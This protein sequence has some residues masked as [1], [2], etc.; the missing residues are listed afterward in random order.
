[1][2][3]KHW[4]TYTQCKRDV[5]HRDPWMDIKMNSGNFFFLLSTTLFEYESHLKTVNNVVLTIAYRNDNN[6]NTF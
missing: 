1:M 6:N 5:Q 2:K 3:H 4:T